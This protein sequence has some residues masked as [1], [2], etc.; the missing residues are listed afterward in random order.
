MFTVVL[1]LFKLLNKQFYVNRV[2]AGHHVL[3]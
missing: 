3:L 1:N 2:V